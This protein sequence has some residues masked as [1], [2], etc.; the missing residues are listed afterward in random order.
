MSRVLTVEEVAAL[1][2]TDLVLIHLLSLAEALRVGDPDAQ[3]A[4]LNLI[5]PDEWDRIVRIYRG[6]AVHASHV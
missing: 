2:D 1:T 4:L 5:R 3:R 6:A